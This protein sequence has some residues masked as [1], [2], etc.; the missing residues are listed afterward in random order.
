MKRLLRHKETGLY[1]APDGGW[2]R[3]WRKAMPISDLTNILATCK[4][5]ELPQIEFVLKSDVGEYDVTLDVWQAR[6]SGVPH[7]LYTSQIMAKINDISEIRRLH[8]FD[9][10]RNQAT[11]FQAG[12]I[13]ADS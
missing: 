8:E 1:F 3:D 10:R 7:F 13:A 12:K 11:A 6:I 4:E 2:V 5:H 9:A